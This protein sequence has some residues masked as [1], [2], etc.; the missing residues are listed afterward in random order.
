MTAARVLGAKLTSYGVYR[1]TTTQSWGV[2]RV[3]PV[4]DFLRA[5]W[6]GDILR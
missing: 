2:T 6:D 4:R 3:L 5:L 1:G